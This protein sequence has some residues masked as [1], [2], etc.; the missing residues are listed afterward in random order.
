MADEPP[1]RLLLVEGIDDEHVV[2]RLLDRHQHMPNFEISDKKGFPN[3]R[4]SIGPEL[5]VPGRTALG[6]LVD[7]NDDF[8][9]RW[10]SIRHQLRGAP[11]TCRRRQLRRLEPSLTARRGWE[12]G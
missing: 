9:A 10:D 6:I 3:L 2:R 12:S 8:N 4:D 7:A 1:G 11:S 5:K